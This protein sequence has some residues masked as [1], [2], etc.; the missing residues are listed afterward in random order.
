MRREEEDEL[1][2][3]K[4]DGEGRGLYGKE[5]REDGNRKEEDQKKSIV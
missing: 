5:R 2:K 4:E 1:G 3:R